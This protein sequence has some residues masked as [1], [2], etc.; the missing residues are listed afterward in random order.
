MKHHEVRLLQLCF[1][2]YMIAIEAH[3][4]RRVLTDVAN[5]LRRSQAGKLDRRRSLSMRFRSR[6]QRSLTNVVRF[7]CKAWR[8]WIMRKGSGVRNSTTTNQELG[9]RSL[10]AAVESFANGFSMMYW[11]QAGAGTERDQRS[12]LLRRY[13]RISSARACRS[14]RDLRRQTL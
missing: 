5:E 10:N 6:G 12:V 13:F 9:T 11:R 2:F 8:H 7:L 4:T 14:L 1:D 3:W